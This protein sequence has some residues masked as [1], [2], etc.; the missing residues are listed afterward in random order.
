MT[1]NCH[2]QWCTLFSLF[3]YLCSRYTSL[4]MIRANI[5]GRHIMS[6]TG[7]KSESCLKTYTDYT[8]N[9][10]KKTMC[11][12]VSDSLTSSI[13]ATKRHAIIPHI[14]F[15]LI[16]RT[17]NQKYILRIQLFLVMHKFLGRAQNVIICKLKKQSF[18]IM[19][20]FLQN[21]THIIQNIQYK[22]KDK[23]EPKR[24]CM[25][26]CFNVLLISLK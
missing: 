11:I 14:Y 12:I 10:T 13:P 5:A 3:Y 17:L 9:K 25:Y 19:N 1:L 7:H 23:Q 24:R 6:V 16:R 22:I 15:R 18:R 8:S 20:R 21:N 2:W 4:N 26:F